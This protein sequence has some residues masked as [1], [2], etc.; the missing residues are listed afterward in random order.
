MSKK[1]K[2]KVVS[3]VAPQKKTK[4]S[5]A[6]A[7]KQTK[8]TRSKRKK[9]ALNDAF[10]IRNP[11]D[12]FSP[13]SADVHLYGGGKLCTTNTKGYKT[14]GNR[15]P[16]ELVLDSTEGFVPLWG[17][18]V[19]L[20]WKFD[21]N[22]MNYFQHPEAAKKRIRELFGQAVLSWGDA[23]PI[24]FRETRDVWDFQIRVSASD[25]CS[26][27][28]CTLASAFFPDQGRHQ[29]VIYPKM[30]TQDEK[31]QVET[32]IHEIGHIFGLRHFFAK[33]T[34]TEW[35]SVIF[36][37][38]N[39]FSIMNYGEYSQ[40]TDE[41]IEDLKTLYTKVWNGELKEIN[42]TKLV[43]VRPYHELGELS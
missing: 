25:N 2:K 1:T 10:A 29:L 15:S 8:R 26:T 14:P 35:E 28:G 5:N 11:S 4:I 7:S 31:E 21:E 16:V 17:E 40:L 9:G 43:Q 20:R 12:P 22:G 30:F 32:L 34:E 42:S 19:T 39:K 24:K 37:E 36:G 23:V 3:K 6:V 38:H 18:G 33:I 13:A 41:D 27:D